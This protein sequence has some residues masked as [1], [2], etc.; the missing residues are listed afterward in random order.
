[1]QTRE[2]VMIK[3]SKC[4]FSNKKDSIFCANCGKPLVILHICEKCEKQ[5]D[6]KNGFC[7][8]D[9]G[10]IVEKKIEDSTNYDLSIY[11]DNNVLLYILKFFLIVNIL[12]YP[13]F[14]GLV[15]DAPDFASESLSF[16]CNFKIL[17]DDNS[18]TE[19]IKFAIS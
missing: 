13:A 15:F 10:V 14:I 2:N 5:Y 6:D 18:S 9:G 12:A 11:N 4:N 19:A 17:K 3:C 1:M 16:P 7:P 8:D